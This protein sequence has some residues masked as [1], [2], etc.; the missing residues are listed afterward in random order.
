VAT[1]FAFLFPKYRLLFFCYALVVSISR[2]IIDAHYLGDIIAGAYI[3]MLTV[4]L[5][6]CYF[7]RSILD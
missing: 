4:F 5:L 7:R 3:G 2:V 1:A 6:Y